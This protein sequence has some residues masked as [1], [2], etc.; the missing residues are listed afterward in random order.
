MQSA[1]GT[2]HL[3][4]ALPDVWL[5]AG[6]VTGL[7][8]RGGFELVSMQWR[9]GKVVKVVIKSTIGGN[10]RLRIPNEMKLGNGTFL[11]KATGENKNPFYQ[12]EKIAN[13]IISER[14]IVTFPAIKE[15]FVYDVSTKAGQV[16]TLILK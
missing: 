16:V 12:T 11:K 8:A 5:A 10:L 4:P 9:N 6:N 15:T 3:V 7:R 1:D 13:P 2:M 14:A